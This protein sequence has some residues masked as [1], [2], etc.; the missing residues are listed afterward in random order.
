MRKKPQRN[1]CILLI[2]LIA[3][4]LIVL[5]NTFNLA[6]VPTG[7]LHVDGKYIKDLN[8]NIVI[9]KGVNRGQFHDESTGAWGGWNTFDIN[10]V[11]FELDEMRS[12]G[13]NVLRLYTAINFWKDDAQHRQYIK[14]VISEARQR[15]IYVVYAPW[16]VVA[17]TGITAKFPY[18]PYISSSTITSTDD[19]V[20][21]WSDVATELG[22]Y[23]N[24][25]FD[26][27]NE[28][29]GD[30]NP[31]PSETQLWFNVVQQTINT[32]RSRSQNLIVI[33]YRSPYY[34]NSGRSGEGIDWIYQY[35]LS[36][37][38]IVYSPHIYTNGMG[39]NP[40]ST[41]YE[42]ILNAFTYEKL[43][44]TDKPV[45]IGEIGCNLLM[46]QDELNRFN[47]SLSILNEWNIGYAAW[48][49]WAGRIWSLNTNVWSSYPP[50]ASG[51]ILKVAIA[52]ENIPPPLTYSC[53]YGDGLSFGSQ[54]ELDA[55]VA[56][57]HPDMS[58]PKSFWQQIVDSWNAFWNW[59][60]EILFKWWLG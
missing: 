24:V 53:P 14:D 10:S 40:Y 4:A 22:S 51:E 36:G 42:Q 11:R 21:Y 15:G 13:I 41:T 33:S 27:W 26:L 58:P 60:Y 57:A 1:Y 3:V 39:Y 29:G 31:T 17:R 23:D 55:H 6:I 30:I 9:L 28:A 19:F 5:P 18:P 34:D 16:T 44:I 48:E 59:V 38:N 8:N 32:I 2:I 12:W 56:S 43:N 49:W 45:W 25:L 7:A 46:G 50:S 20:N 52:E 54:A 37:S 35:P 47:Y